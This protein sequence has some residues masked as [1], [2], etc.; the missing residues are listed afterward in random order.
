[1]YSRAI[2][3]SS[4]RRWDPSGAF[5]RL[6]AAG[7]LAIILLTWITPAAAAA[8]P[9]ND[10]EKAVAHQLHAKATAAYSAGKRKRAIELWREAIQLHEFW[11]YAYNMAYALYEEEQHSE[12][13]TWLMRSKALGFPADQ[14]KL[15]D[16]LAQLRVK[17]STAMLRTHAWV[18]LDV[19]PA[20]AG[21]RRNGVLWPAPRG[22]WTQ[23]ATTTIRVEADDFVAQEFVWRHAAQH[24]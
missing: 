2:R 1:M 6:M 20:H 13:W 11:K 23:E 3:Q 17:V 21:V 4:T 19:S 14:P 12:A 10:T 9:P 15:L 5:G 16:L 22:A 7:A 24:R 18:E 8:P